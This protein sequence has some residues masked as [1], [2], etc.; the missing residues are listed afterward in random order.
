MDTIIELIGHTTSRSGL[1]VYAMEDKNKYPA[2]IK[3]SDDELELLNITPNK[4]LGKWNYKISPRT[5]DV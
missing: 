4:I 1:K 3:I 2:G 5:R